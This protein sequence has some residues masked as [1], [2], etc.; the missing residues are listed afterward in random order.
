MW[1]AHKL[2]ISC[3]NHIEITLSCLMLHYIAQANYHASS[4]D[5]TTKQLVS[6]MGSIKGTWLYISSIIKQQNWRT[7]K[8]LD[9][10]NY[11]SKGEN[12]GRRRNW[13]TLPSLQHYGGGGGVE[14]RARVMGC[15]L[16]QVT[17]KS[18]IHT[19]LH[20]PNNKLVSA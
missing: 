7:P 19:N 18:I 1:I 2:A 20:K 15:G 14:G 11:E 4:M 12:S 5:H 6:N 9:R 16:R 10:L 8:L 13:G 3:L 17:S